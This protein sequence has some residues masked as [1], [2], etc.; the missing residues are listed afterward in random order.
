[1]ENPEPS[2]AR[3]AGEVEALR[4]ALTIA[5]SHLPE[6]AMRDV[7]QHLRTAVRNADTRIDMG[8]AHRDFAAGL[9]DVAVEIESTII[10]QIDELA[11]GARV[12][13]IEPARVPP[14]DAR[15]PAD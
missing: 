15:Q 6:L 3:L 13:T 8:A 12:R 4:I 7:G 2:L 11:S 5:V 14:G 1:M 10:Q 9:H